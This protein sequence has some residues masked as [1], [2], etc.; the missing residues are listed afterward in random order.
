MELI[1][2]QN[3]RLLTNLEV[4]K[5][6]KDKLESKKKVR[7][8]QTLLY[9]SAKYLNTKSPCSKQTESGVQGFAND[10]KVFDLTKSEILMLINHCPSSQVE[11]S[12]IISDLDSRLSNSQADQLL[13][14]VQ[15]HFPD[16]VTASQMINSTGTLEA[17]EDVT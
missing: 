6:I 10:V 3:P 11:L 8:Q 17:S 14:L 1:D 9:T 5:L 2:P 7:R 16:G 12:V 13:Q 15:K 4:L